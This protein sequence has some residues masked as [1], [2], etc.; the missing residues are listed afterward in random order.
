[1]RNSV[2][3]QGFSVVETILVLVVIA[4]LGFT[5]WFVWH[6]GRTADRTLG[7]PSASESTLQDK[8][9]TTTSKMLTGKVDSELTF[10]YPSSWS[11]VQTSKETYRSTDPSDQTYTAETTQLTKITSPSGNTTVTIEGGIGGVGG[12]CLPEEVGTLTN[13]EKTVLPNDEAN[14][15]A[16]YRTSEGQVTFAVVDAVAAKEANTGVSECALA[17]AGLLKNYHRGIGQVSITYKPFVQSTYTSTASENS[18]KAYLS[19]AEYSAAL[20]IVKSIKQ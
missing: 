3:D 1:M 9:A 10:S 2:N 12:A 8:S 4:I 20:N 11:V 13:I 17:F 16:A 6:A 5:G 19:S 7:T 18:F 15:F 14:V